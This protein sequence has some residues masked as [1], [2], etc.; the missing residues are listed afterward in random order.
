MAEQVDWIRLAAG[1]RFEALELS[2]VASLLVTNDRLR[3]AQELAERRGWQGVTADAVL[4]MPA[5]LIGTIDQISED[6]RARRTRLDLAYFI[7]TD[8]DLESAAPLVER[9]SAT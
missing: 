8:R 2:V 7:F 6:L 4:D 3:D 5:V 9:L 1:P